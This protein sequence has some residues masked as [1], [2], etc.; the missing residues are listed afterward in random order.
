[1]PIRFETSHNE[2]LW[3]RILHQ[4]GGFNVAQFRPHWNLKKR[5]TLDA[6]VTKICEF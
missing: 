6:M 1:M 5:P 3:P 4:A 2:D